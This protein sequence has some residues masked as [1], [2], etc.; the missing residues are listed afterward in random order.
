MGK[1]RD[2]KLSR[3]LKGE[4]KT[5][6]KSDFQN[7]DK[8]KTDAVKSHTSKK[9]KGEKTDD[10]PAKDSMKGKNSNKKSNKKINKQTIPASSD[11]DV[12]QNKKQNKKE[13]KKQNKKET[14]PA[15]PKQV[16]HKKVTPS[17][18]TKPKLNLRRKKK[19]EKPLPAKNLVRC[20]N[21]DL[22][23]STVDH[24]I[25]SNFTLDLNKSL[26]NASNDVESDSN[27]NQAKKEV[28]NSDLGVTKGQ[29]ITENCLLVDPNLERVVEDENKEDKDTYIS[30]DSCESSEEE[31]IGKHEPENCKEFNDKD[32]NIEQQVNSIPDNSK[33]KTD[34]KHDHVKGS[35]ETH[36]LAT[37]TCAKEQNED[38]DDSDIEI[39]C[40]IIKAA[41]HQLTTIKS[42]IKE[43]LE[44]NQDTTEDKSINEYKEKFLEQENK[45]NSMEKSLKVIVDFIQKGKQDDLGDLSKLI[46]SKPLATNVLP[47]TIDI[48]GNEPEDEVISSP[49]SSPSSDAPLS[50][51]KRK[52]NLHGS[53]SRQKK[54][55]SHETRDEF[56]SPSRLVTGIQIL[57]DSETEEDNDNT[58]FNGA[59]DGEGNSS[60]DKT[61]KMQTL[62]NYQN[63][64][65]ISRSTGMKSHHSLDWSKNSNVPDEFWHNFPWADKTKDMCDGKEL[66]EYIVINKLE[67]V[68]KEIAPWICTAWPIDLYEIRYYSYTDDN[69]DTWVSR[70]LAQSKKFFLKGKPLDPFDK[71]VICQKYLVSE[72]HVY[73]PVFLF[74]ENAPKTQVW[75]WQNSR[76]K[77]CFMHFESSRSEKTLERNPHKMISKGGSRFSKF[78]DDLEPL[79]QLQFKQSDFKIP[80]EY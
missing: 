21:Y 64:E 13:N 24:D 30:D 7:D 35:D 42:E 49:R 14:K 78:H 52:S 51:R 67:H 70:T 50:S 79:P 63:Y 33:G 29:D 65:R 38:D 44:E 76:E 6:D 9:E 45:I 3:K 20:F 57:S 10:K 5:S 72:Y 22:E 4:N 36:T 68:A 32:E 66:D 73:M 77:A 18:P 16:K 71:C 39:L 25:E 60:G 46:D 56:F 34:G 80:N 69:K 75:K 8:P 37:A 27:L 41:P 74:H 2:K 23:N 11:R 62:N 47:S 54:I 40:E 19:K 53:S 59:E 31:T 12:K 15:T 61:S 58:N 28:I 26:G 17:K 48:P 55:K 43:E 1:A